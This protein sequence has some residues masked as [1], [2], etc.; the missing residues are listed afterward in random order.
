MI[1][2]RLRKD[3]ENQSFQQAVASDKPIRSFLK[4]LTWRVIGTLDTM[5]VSYF[6]VSDVKIAS[7]IAGVDFLTKMILYFFHE[8]LWSTIKWGR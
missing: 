6:V 3:K 4:A 8:R 7:T 5:L 1:L 2:D